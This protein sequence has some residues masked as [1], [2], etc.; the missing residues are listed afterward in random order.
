MAS[1][2]TIAR[3][4]SNPPGRITRFPRRPNIQWAGIRR[5]DKPSPRRG[6]G[7][8]ARAEYCMVQDPSRPSVRALVSAGLLALSRQV[9]LGTTARGCNSRPPRRPWSI[10]LPTQ[11][12][13]ATTTVTLTKTTQRSGAPPAPTAGGVLFVWPIRHEASGVYQNRSSRPRPFNSWSPP[14][15]SSRHPHPLPGS[16]P[17]A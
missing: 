17:R 1:S 8:W 11:K 16:A 14:G 10:S 3:D 5:N 15:V 7:E 12:S 4:G 13:T 9:T 6:T 2:V